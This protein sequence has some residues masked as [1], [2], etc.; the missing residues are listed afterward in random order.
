MLKEGSFSYILL[1]CLLTAEFFCMFLPTQAETIANPGDLL[2]TEVQI[3]GGEGLTNN[4]YIK[5][6]N[7]TDHDIDLKGFRLVKRIKDDTTDDSIKSWSASVIIPAQGY[8]LWANS[9]FATDISAD[10]STG[11]S[12]T[13]R[14]GSDQAN[15]NGVAIRLGSMDSGIIIDSVGWDNCN[16]D[17]VKINPVITDNCDARYFIIIKRDANNTNTDNNAQDFAVVCTAKET[18]DNNPPTNEGDDQTT[19]TTTTQSG[20]NVRVDATIF[21]DEPYDNSKIV[22]NNSDEEDEEKESEE[23]T[24]TEEAKQEEIKLPT[25]LISEFLPDPLGADNPDNC[26]DCGEFIEL[27]NYSSEAINLSGWQIQVD[28]RPPYTFSYYNFKPKARLAIYRAQ[29]NLILQNNQGKIILKD[30]QKIIQTINYKDATPNYAYA[31][32]ESS[33]QLNPNWVWSKTMSPGEENYWIVP[34]NKPPITNF[35]LPDSIDIKTTINLDASDSYDPEGQALTYIWDFGDGQ[36]S[37]EQSPT[38]LFQKTGTLTVQLSVS[39]GED[40][41]VVSKK[42]KVTG[43]NPNT[44]TEKETLSPKPSIKATPKKS[45]VNNFVATGSIDKVKTLSAGTKTTVI[46]TVVVPPNIFGS[47]YLQIVDL[48]GGMQVYSNKKD[49]PELYIGDQIQASGE[50]SIVSGEYRLKTASQNDIKLLL[51]KHPPASQ[52]IISTDLSQDL[53]GSFVNVTGTIL[54]SKNDLVYLEDQAGEITIQLKENTGLKNSDFVVGNKVKVIGIVKPSGTGFRIWVREPNDLEILETPQVL[55]EKITSEGDINITDQTV[56]SLI[57]P[58]KNK[59]LE[60]YQY[61][62]AFAAGIIAV[63]IVWIVRLKK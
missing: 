31:L 10:S 9:S 29:S 46:G 56:P 28:D 16:N 13:N 38:H 42:I 53:L 35:F 7:T 52:P 33:A 12:I 24:K 1:L 44:K 5:I 48:T 49:F 62:L 8:H 2:I 15:G 20:G 14:T 63:L 51:Q 3:T 55:G 57:I 34:K 40:K 4:D 61:L 39:D 27:T 6:Y 50:I 25:I 26:S 47:Q 22:T 43:E 30:P 54:E 59:G 60:I 11:A 32:I 41:T 58:A 18:I 23:K 37:F 17:F 21:S 45:S 36:T 19:T